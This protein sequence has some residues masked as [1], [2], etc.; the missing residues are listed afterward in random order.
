MSVV[1]VILVIMKL[2][3]MF[4]FGERNV[5]SLK[6][7][8]G[9]IRRVICCCMIELSLVIVSVIWFVVKVIG[10][11]WKLLFE[12]ILLVLVMISGLLVI[13]LVLIISV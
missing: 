8:D 11:V 3:L 10:L 5:G 7:R 12:R 4:G 6:F 9:L 13:E 2:E 1:V